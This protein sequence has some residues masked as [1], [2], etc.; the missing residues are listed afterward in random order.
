[1]NKYLL[2]FVC[3]IPFFYKIFPW[4]LGKYYSLNLNQ[5]KSTDYHWDL[6][7]S[8]SW[9]EVTVHQSNFADYFSKNWLI[10]Q[11]KIFFPLMNQWKLTDITVKRKITDSISENLTDSDLESIENDKEHPSTS[12]EWKFSNNFYNYL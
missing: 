11:W 8:N 5:S 7:D 10:W 6:T 12:F 9:K 3:K 1:M 4:K 2:K